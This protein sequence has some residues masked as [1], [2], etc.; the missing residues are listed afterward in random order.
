MRWST[1]AWTSPLVV[2]VLSMAAPAMAEPEPLPAAVDWPT[3]A[4]IAVARSPRLA[5]VRGEVA[6]ARTDAVTAERYPNPSLGYELDQVFAGANPGNLQVHALTLQQPLMLGGQRSARRRA[7]TLAVAT[8]E[9]GVAVTR[10]E[11][12][13]ELRATWIDAVAKQAEAAELEAGV[14][15]LDALVA[16][17]AER[18]KLGHA[19]AFDTRRVEAEVEGMKGELASTRVESQVASAAIGVVLGLPGWQPTVT[20]GL[21]E[22]A[23]AQAAGETAVERA[24]EREVD[25]AR[26]DVSLA[27]AERWPDLVVSAGATFGRDASTEGAVV[28]L[29][30]ELPV[31]DFGRGRLA[32]AQAELAASAERRDATKAEADARRSAL[33]AMVEAKAAALDRFDDDYLPRVEDVARLADEAYQGGVATLLDLLDA[34]H[35]A[36]GARR[37]R[38]GLVADLRHAE[39]DLAAARGALDAP[40]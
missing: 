23:A 7:A 30:W 9:A 12:L 14:K 38:I 18:A 29:S 3:L 15:R 36:I 13:H 19:S 24:A 26:A 31:F 33:A 25:A 5:A 28:G 37:D 32:R 16:V 4:R 6:V 35:N 27:K 34:L 22:A 20:G 8:A 1:R 2:A 21:D 17:V 39:A 40:P 10:S 11:L